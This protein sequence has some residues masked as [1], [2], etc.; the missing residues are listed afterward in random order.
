MWIYRIQRK[1]IEL[2][3]GWLAH[4]SKDRKH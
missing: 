3:R 4:F 2:V 1:R